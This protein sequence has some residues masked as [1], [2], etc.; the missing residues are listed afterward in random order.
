MKTEVIMV[1][2]LFGCDIKQKSKSEFFSS[3]DLIKAGNKWRILNDLPPFNFNQ[4]KNNDSTK[5]FIK[6]IEDKFGSAIIS[7]KG[8]GN[9]T[10]VH[11]YLFLDI[12]LAIDPKLKIEVYQWLFDSLLKFR[13]DSGDSYKKMCGALYNNTTCKT[14]FSK[15]IS[16]VAD[17]IRIECGVKDWQN[18]DEWQ[19]KL[20]D[21]IHEYIS[22]F[23][24]MFHNNNDEAVRVGIIKGKE[25]IEKEKEFRAKIPF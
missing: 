9:N 12:A 11:P 16:G 17:T 7:G 2:Q 22:L 13:N 18:A 8:R 4:W 25:F 21:K 3:T 14:S 23:C 20:R 6:E 10:W 15:Y 19:L 1:R 5:E 24:D